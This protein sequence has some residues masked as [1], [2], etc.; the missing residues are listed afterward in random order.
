M[1]TTPSAVTNDVPCSSASAGAHDHSAR[2]VFAPRFDAARRLLAANATA[3]P[4]AKGAHVGAVNS[5]APASA[6]LSRDHR[7]RCL[8]DACKQRRMLFDE[9]DHPGAGTGA[10]AS[11]RFR[12]SRRLR[13]RDCR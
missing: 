6:L 2:D 4:I 13:G 10:S 5:P 11:P 1:R 9:C 12:E 7:C 8:Q 3:L